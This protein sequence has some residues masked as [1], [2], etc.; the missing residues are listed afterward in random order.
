MTT[1]LH[2]CQVVNGV[3][4]EY[5]FMIRLNLKLFCL[6]MLDADSSTQRY[7][8]IS[9]HKPKP[10]CQIHLNFCILFS[11]FWLFV[12]M[13]IV[14]SIQWECGKQN[15]FI[16]KL[17]N[18]FSWHRYSYAFRIVVLVIH[19]VL[20]FWCGRVQVDICRQETVTYTLYKIKLFRE[21]LVIYLILFFQ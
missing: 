20:L 4:L 11:L 10:M 12:L 5:C 8:K 7:M 2:G 16:R 14:A 6:L 19:S 21:K 1:P 3:L 15:E 13:Q 17:R 9:F 18:Y